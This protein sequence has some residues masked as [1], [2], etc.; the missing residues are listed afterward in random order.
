MRAATTLVSLVALVLVVL[1]ESPGAPAARTSGAMPA[2]TISVCS[3]A[4]VATML[5]ERGALQN[6]RRAVVLLIQARIGAC[7]RAINR[8]IA[9]LSPSPIIARNPPG[10]PP[11][12]APSPVTTAPA[13]C[14]QAP[15]GSTKSSNDPFQLYSALTFCVSWISSNVPLPSSGTPTPRPI[16]FHTPASG[17]TD[18]WIRPVYVLAPASDANVSAAISLKMADTLRSS[19][20]NSKLPKGATPPPVPDI[21]SDRLV[22]YRVLAEPAWTLAQYQQQCF[23]DP[24]TAGA[25]V[26]LQPGTAS[27]LFSFFLNRSVTTV[28][29]QLMVVDCEPTNTAYVNS[30]AYITY[31]SHVRAKQGQR[32][33]LNLSQLL[34]ATALYFAFK[35]PNM[36]TTTFKIH[37]TPVPSNKPAEIGYTTST[38]LSGVGVAA[39]D[40]AGLA[41]FNA[42][43]DQ[44]S[45]DAQ[46]ATAIS[47]LLPEMIDDLMRPC[48]QLRPADSSFVQPQCEWFKYYQP[49]PNPQP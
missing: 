49:L 40:V 25:I 17:S 28:T 10:L 46:I 4:D 42:L 30:A 1:A 22:R 12:P 6:N 41:P 35:P 21:Y 44:P 3:T 32:F 24:S 16:G 7:K 9:G 20:M 43:G 38:N 45:G 29:M 11:L 13:E 23:S 33:S 19:Y 34:G 26:A 27:T 15:P 36:T 5:G 2:Y 39:V 37:P 48:Q 31:L 8:Y 47:K 18:T 14:R